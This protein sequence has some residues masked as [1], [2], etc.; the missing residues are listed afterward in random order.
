MLYNAVAND[1]KMM[2]PYLVNSIKSNGVVVKEI[3]PTVLDQQICSPAVIKAAR[4]AMEAVVTEGTAKAV[5]TD[6]PFPVAGKTGTAHVAGGD[7]KYYDGV[8]QASFAGYFPADKPEYTCVVVIKT[9]PH[10]AIHY[11]GQLAA[12][13]FREVANKLY[14]M[15]V[16]KK[17]PAAPVM[18]RDSV[19]QVYAGHT[20]DVQQVFSGLNV[21]YKDS[22]QGKTWSVIHSSYAGNVVKPATIKKKVIP[23]VRNMTLRD[24]LYVLESLD[25]TVQA[26][27]KGK[28]LMQDILP[29]TPLG[30]NQTIILLLN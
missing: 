10:A 2:K 3:E 14:A 22:A 28:V 30:K 8:Y 6:S 17:K 12:P 5:F 9:K 25:V 1:G 24:A 29:G 7:V 4:A 13:V 19:N 26:K 16:Q 27:G 20:K 23:D 18:K 15:Y 11:G 21:R